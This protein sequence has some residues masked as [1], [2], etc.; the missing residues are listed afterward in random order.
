VKTEPSGRCI[1]KYRRGQ[2]DVQILLKLAVRDEKVVATAP[3]F[4]FDVEGFEGCSVLRARLGVETISAR[5]AEAN[6]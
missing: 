6:A 2:A 1:L 3:G 4:A 5:I